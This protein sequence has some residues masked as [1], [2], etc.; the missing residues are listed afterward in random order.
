MELPTNRNQLIALG[1]AGALILAGG[2]FLVGRALAPSAEIAEIAEAAHAEEGEEHGPEGFLVMT[3]E[4]ARAAGIVIEQ[5]HG[6]GLAAEIVAQ[7]M[8]MPTPAGEAILT[9]RADGTVVRIDRRLGDYVRAGEAVATMDSREAAALASQRSSAEA[10]LALARSSF[11]RE[12]RLYEAKV[13]AR[14]DFEGARAALAEAEAEAR[15]SRS[16]ASASLVSGDGRSLAVVSVIS[17]RITKADAKLGAFVPAG[18][19]LF[20]VADPS[21]VQVNVSVLAADARRIQPGDAGIIELANGETRNAVVRSLTPGL[22]PESRSATVVLQPDGIGG[23]TQGQ[24]L[25]VRVRPAGGG[26]T[27]RIALPEEA[28]Q[29]V[30]G[31]DVV[32]VRTANGFQAMN[33]VAGQRSGG[34][35]EI[36]DGLKAGMTVATRGA[37][38]LKAELGK[39]EAE[40]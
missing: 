12:K 26:D 17:G 37:F 7:G 15:R 28:V 23:L 19:E 31:R 30:E 2:G 38:L 5:V 6:G 10:R 24:G 21:S 13:T 32:F 8:V 4:R 3:P 27:G 39:G 18:T 25:R 33:V 9:A 36:I 14:Q 11:E 16:A 34:R 1:A 29:S 22:D 35:I 40:H 20:R